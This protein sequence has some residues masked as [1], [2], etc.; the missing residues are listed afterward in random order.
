M[1]GHDS[2]RRKG[3]NNECEASPVAGGEEKSREHHKLRACSIELGKRLP[4]PQKF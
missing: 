4:V 2:E 1:D 3:D